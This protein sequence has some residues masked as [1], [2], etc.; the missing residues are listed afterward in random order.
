MTEFSKN[1]ERCQITKNTKQGKDSS[2]HFKNET[3]KTK[4]TTKQRT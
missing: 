4:A 2:T 1:N 3:N